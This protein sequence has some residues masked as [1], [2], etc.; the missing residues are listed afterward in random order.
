[1]TNDERNPKRKIRMSA[2]FYPTPQRG[3]VATEPDRG[4]CQVPSL[5][6]PQPQRQQCLRGTRIPRF[7]VRLPG[8]LPLPGGRAGVR[9]N[10]VAWHNSISPAAVRICAWAMVALV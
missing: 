10:W 1:M 3:A 8:G 6:D 7:A 5:R 2:Y 9:G 4:C